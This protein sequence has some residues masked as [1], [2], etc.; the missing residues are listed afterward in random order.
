METPPVNMVDLAIAGVML[1]SGALAFFRGL[2]RETFFIAGL[3]A[4][5]AAVYYGFDHALPFAR[6][7]IAIPLIDEAAATASIT[8]VTLVSVSLIGGVFVRRIRKIGLGALDRSLGLVFGLLR[9][10]ALI[11][12]A[13]IMVTW[14][15]P[16]DE[17]PTSMREAR[18][19][20]LV[21]YGADLVL[22]AIPPDARAEWAGAVVEATGAADAAFD[23]EEALKTLM[24]PPAALEKPGGS[25]YTRAERKELER[26][27]QS[28]Q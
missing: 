4:A 24:S 14:A 12:I 25:G 11:C 19:M 2:V 5:G 3:V 7:W 13:Y 23:A 10:A 1:I 17:Q 28:T 16:P 6:E 15:L 22:L 18:A 9:G 21:K 27:L 8:I 20:P 26:L